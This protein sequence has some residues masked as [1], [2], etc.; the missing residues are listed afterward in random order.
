MTFLIRFSLLAFCI[1]SS[2]LGF[3]GTLPDDEC[4]ALTDIAK[5]LGKK[6][7]DF[8]VNPCSGENN[9][10]TPKPLK[11][12]DNSVSCTCNGTLCHVFSITLKRQNLTGS[13]PPELIRLPYLQNFDV[14]RNYLN[15]TI[16]TEWGSMN[17]VN[18]SLLGNRLSGPIPI[19]LGNITTLKSLVLESN[20]FSGELPPELGNLTQ[21]ERLHISANNFTGEIPATFAQLTSLKHVRIGDNQFNG[22]IPDFIQNWTDLEKLLIQG[23]GLSGPIPSGISFL[24]NL[25]ELTISDLN[26]PDSTFPVFKNNL[27]NWHILILRSCNINGT[28]PEYLGDMTELKTL[29]LSFNKLSGQIPSTFNGLRKAEN[30]FLTGNFLTG[31]LPEGME[32]AK[33][34]DLSYNNFSIGNQ[35]QLT[36]AKENMNLFASSSTNDSGTVAC[37][38]SSGCLKTYYYLRINCGGTQVKIHGDNITY[39]GD[40]DEGG[41]SRF[42]HAGENWAFS[43]TGYFVDNSLFKNIYTRSNESRLSMNN[44]E[45]YMNARVSANSLTYYG[46]C[47]RNGNYT[48]KLHFAEI[49]FTDDKTYS[50]L[51]RRI[52]DIYIQRKL[53]LKD[54]NIAKEAGGV[55]KAVVK[56]FTA[57]VTS[58]NL[59]IR[60]YW[61]GKGTTEIP[62]KSVY[63]PLI[64]AISVDP[65]FEVATQSTP[66]ENKSSLPTGAVVAIAASTAV[67]IVILVLGILWWRGFL[68]HKCWRTREL[69]GVDMQTGLFTLRQIKAAT[70]NFSPANKIGEGGFGPV[71]KGFLSDDTIIASNTIKQPMEECFS[72]LDWAHLLKEEGNLM[73]LVDRRLGSDFNQEEAMVM[74]K[75]AL[76]CTNV[77]STLRPTMSSVVSMLEGKI[78]VPEIVSDTGETMEEMKLEG[79]RLH[80]QQIEAQTQRDS[81]DR[82]FTA[83]STSAVDLYPVQPNSS[84]MEK[85]N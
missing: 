63:G 48:V 1:V 80:Y 72:L 17:L 15:G 10:V 29:D 59:E 61:A 62:D 76:L 68:G 85:R 26:G 50:S 53:V 33:Y 47:L 40:S 83:S 46:Y 66:L 4:Q 28:L 13:L 36:C 67:V 35:E 27:S 41:P 20:Q 42:H 34:I 82:S 49:I 38:G 84:F 21:L 43:N 78:V 3:N 58:G 57:V 18:I 11:G 31:S 75:V 23:S 30:I 74:I 2:A 56:N 70:D 44:S 6:D 24:K 52:F 45:L 65:D 51:G 8:S 32:N 19:E 77:T 14:V 5:T 25:T 54:F 12:F 60:F 69:K 81:E 16:P 7:W 39:D 9:W 22:K 73:E 79:L 71:F 64:S 55:H 37:V